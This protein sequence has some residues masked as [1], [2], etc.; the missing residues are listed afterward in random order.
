MW[1]AGT[2]LSQS[3]WMATASSTAMA[4]L[5]NDS[6]AGAI[7]GNMATRWSSGHP[8]M[9]GDWFEVD[10]GQ[11]T[12]ISQVLLYLLVGDAGDPSD[13]PTSYQ[14]GLSTDNTAFNTVATGGGTAPTTAIC[15]ARQEARYV[16]ITQTGTAPVAWWSINEIAVVP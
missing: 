4:D 10:L 1:A 15:F 2:G 13:A 9:S 11:P 14:L 5:N 16:K 7:D 8:Q 6:I 12:M 3:G